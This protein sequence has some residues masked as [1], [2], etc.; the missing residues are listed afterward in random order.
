MNF[1]GM[2]PGELMLIM[3]LALIVFG[4]QKLPEIGQGL[5]K[6]IG[7]FRRAT[8]QIT[9]EI[10]REL[11][12]ETPPKTETPPTPAAPAP[13]PPAPVENPVAGQT[14]NEPLVLE[15]K[16]P[17]SSTTFEA[18][19]VNE[20]PVE[21]PPMAPVET[22]PE[23]PSAYAPAE[24]TPVEAPAAVADVPAKP[25]RARRTRKVVA[26]PSEPA[27]EAA[28]A[29]ATTVE[30]TPAEATPKKPARRRKVATMEPS[31]E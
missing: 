20:A 29:E 4:P 30:T 19:K 21:A 1:L 8:S 31:N 16:P 28:V 15:I 26:E 14:Q 6:A 24:E 23:S 10:N 3:V 12:L 11:S 18:A 25:A 17:T 22:T 27:P 7:E 2:G 9:D 13:V 5:G